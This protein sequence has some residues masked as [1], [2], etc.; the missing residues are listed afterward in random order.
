LIFTFSFIC[1]YSSFKTGYWEA[2]CVFLRNR[3][4]SMRNRFIIKEALYFQGDKKQWIEFIEFIGFIALFGELALPAEQKFIEL[5][6][7]LCRNPSNHPNNPN[8]GI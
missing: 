5:L 7:G 4:H 8:Q 6:S 2:L 1:L 3:I